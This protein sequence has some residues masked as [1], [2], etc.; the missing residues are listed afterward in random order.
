MRNIK[1]FI[2][3]AS[4]TSQMNHVNKLNKK[5]DSPWRPTDDVIFDA[6]GN[7]LNINDVVLFQYD[8]FSRF[9]VITGLGADLGNGVV[10][11]Q[12]DRGEEEKLAKFLF[13]INP[14][15]F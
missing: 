9:G 2:N 14:K 13:K 6:M 5:L 7:I 11:I 8:D 10:R 1:E 4:Q 3:E 15:M 12:H